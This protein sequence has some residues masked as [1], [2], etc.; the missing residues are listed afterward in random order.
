MPITHPDLPYARNALEPYMSAK[1]FE[2]HH[3]KHLKAYVDNTNKL[4]AGTQ[5]ENA[6]LETIV[7]ET[8]KDSS[9]AGIFNNA[10]QVWN[11]IFFFKCMKPNGGGVP[12]GKIAEMINAAFGS[13]QKFVDEFKNAGVTQFGSGWAWL[14]LDGRQL[15]ASTRRK[16][17]GARVPTHDLPKEDADLTKVAQPNS[18][19]LRI[20]MVANDEADLV[21][22]LR[23]GYEW[24]IAAATLIAREAGAAVS[25]AF[26][27]PLAYNK[28]DPRAFGLLVC[29]PG[30]H[31]AAIE[32]LADRAAILA[33]R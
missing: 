9:K 29:S 21:A 32:Q 25:D 31:T 27:K 12:S 11:H 26:G 22:T 7:K 15:K 28:P 2:F 14:V 6:D 24:D 5:L 33:T 18:I 13:H 20:A 10:A 16:F 17:A 8:A 1:T 19:A 3:G 23:W 4:I 30:I